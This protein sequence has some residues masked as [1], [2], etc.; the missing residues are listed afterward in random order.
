[1]ISNA[2]KQ[3]WANGTQAWWQLGFNT[4]H[5][6]QV[7][8]TRFPSKAV[9]EAYMHGFEEGCAL[10]CA[11]DPCP[12][13]TQTRARFAHMEKQHAALLEDVRRRGYVAGLAG[14]SPLFGSR[15]T[16]CLKAWQAAYQEGA[17]SRRRQY[18]RP[19]GA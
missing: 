9:R 18:G 8:A 14:R 7:A 5:R 15:D 13:L 10:A 1:M 6:K 16:E 19:W 11:P 4:G 3:F 12:A 17:A 2:P